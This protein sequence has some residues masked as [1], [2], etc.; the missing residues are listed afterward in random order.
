[1][2]VFAVGTGWE[3]P[4]LIVLEALIW[5]GCVVWGPPPPPPGPPA[6][7][8][9]PLIWPFWFDSPRITGFSVLAVL[10]SVWFF[11][12]SFFFPSKKRVK[13]LGVIPLCPIS[14]QEFK[15]SLPQLFCVQSTI[16][17]AIIFSQLVVPQY[18]SFVEHEHKMF[19][20]Q[21][22]SHSFCKQEI[23]WN[24][25]STKLFPPSQKYNLKPERG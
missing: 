20:T 8:T 6:G 21:A 9:E 19:V 22:I 17:Q 11:F 10:M 2:T 24:Y 1:M 12:F 7:F 23:H 5:G 16:V 14:L 4:L 13:T 15:V 3:L 18:Q 25:S